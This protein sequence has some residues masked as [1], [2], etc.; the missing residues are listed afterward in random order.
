MPIITRIVG[1]CIRRASGLA[2]SYG[3]ALIT[4]R[5]A[6]NP[7]LL[8]LSNNPNS[9]I[10][11]AASILAGNLVSHPISTANSLGSTINGV[12]GTIL[13]QQNEMARV[14]EAATGR[15]DAMQSTLDQMAT[16]RAI[17]PIA[18]ETAFHAQR[19]AMTEAIGASVQTCS[20][21]IIA[22]QNSI[23]GTVVL[24]AAIGA[25]I[26]VKSGK[27]MVVPTLDTKVI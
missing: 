23:L 26:A 7:N 16:V 6:N 1:F 5:I 3:A 18:F 24:T 14:V 25:L 12:T 9:I 21:A 27:G 10:R 20:D 19:E 17:D 22:R 4:Q 8:N 13:R 15:F 11:T 2:A